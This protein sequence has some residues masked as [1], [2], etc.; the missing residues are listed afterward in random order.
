MKKL[1]LCILALL[2]LAAPVSAE[3]AYVVDESG[4]LQSGQ[5]GFVEDA[6]REVEQTEGFTPI[7][8]TIDSFGGL[9][10]EEYAGNFYDAFGYGPD[11]I[12]LLVSL[13]EGQWY[14]LTNG[15]CA[16]TIS[17]YSASRIGEQ[18]L[19][20]IR[21]GLYYEAFL[22]FAELSVEAMQPEPVA[23]NQPEPAYEEESA[24]GFGGLVLICMGLGLVAAV[25]VMAYLAANMKTV[26][27]KQGASD[28]VRSGSMRL[29][30]SRDI[31]LYSNVT[32][33]PKPKSNASG[34]HSG[35]A[36][37]SHRGGGG[38]RSRGGAGGRI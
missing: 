36:R 15:R 18:V 9:S 3:T 16:E 4:L 31:F 13:T 12:L 34:G 14:I 26:A 20:M 21:D 22:T 17:D 30:D 29:T 2:V 8:V 24:G 7:V 35:G 23:Q 33:T 27:K 11:G 37:G 32:R 1:I 38:S 25:F 19:P 6:F 10:A 5:V 28:Y